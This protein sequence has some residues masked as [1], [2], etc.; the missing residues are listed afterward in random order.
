MMM[1]K[2]LDLLDSFIVSV[3]VELEGEK[4]TD[5]EFVMSHPAFI[6]PL[7][8]IATEFINLIQGDVAKKNE[9]VT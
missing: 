2:A 9:P 7:T 5:I 6:T 1:G 4:H 3:D 8:Q